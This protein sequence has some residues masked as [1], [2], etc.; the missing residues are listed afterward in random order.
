MT[1]PTSFHQTMS[2]FL[3]ENYRNI[4][5]PKGSVIQISKEINQIKLASL[6]KLPA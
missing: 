3:N 5:L 1:F 4:S 6:K 2:S